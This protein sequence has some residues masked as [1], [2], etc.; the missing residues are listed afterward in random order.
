MKKNIEEVN[1]KRDITGIR[2]VQGLCLAIILVIHYTVSYESSPSNYVSDSFMFMVAML[3]ALIA[4]LEFCKEIKYSVE[5][6]VVNVDLNDGD[7]PYYDED[8]NEDLLKREHYEKEHLGVEDDSSYSASPVNT[9]DRP[10]TLGELNS[11]KELF[12]NQKS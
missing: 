3:V 7:D 6:Y 12:K 10:K 8:Y 9:E 4:V 1:R 11:L 2:V 5:D